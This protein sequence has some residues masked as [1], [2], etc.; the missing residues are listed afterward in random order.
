M[1][2]VDGNRGSFNTIE[3][4]IIDHKV[5]LKLSQNQSIAKIRENTFLNRQEINSI[6]QTTLMKFK[7]MRIRSKI[8]FSAF[9]K[10]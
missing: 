7:L 5:K 4:Q 3:E 1:E 6:N 10:N 9:I 8:S 2:T